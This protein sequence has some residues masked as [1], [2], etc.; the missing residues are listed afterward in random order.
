MKHM[1]KLIIIRTD[2]QNNLYEQIISLITANQA[3]M[4]TMSFGVFPTLF[5]PG[6]EITLNFRRDSR[7]PKIAFWQSKFPKNGSL[8]INYCD[9]F[10]KIV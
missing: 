4:E 1:D 3:K 6:L 8:F 9:I 7:Y 5:F 10:E 2:N